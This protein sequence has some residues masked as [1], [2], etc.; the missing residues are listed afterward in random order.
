MFLLLLMHV[1]MNNKGVKL[2][3]QVFIE[4]IYF[5]VFQCTIASIH[6]LKFIRMGKF[7]YLENTTM[8]MAEMY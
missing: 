4:I 2:F 6:L 7:T 1:S 3:T 8:Q 5:S